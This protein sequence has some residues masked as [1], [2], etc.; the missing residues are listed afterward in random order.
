MKTRK[1]I[2]QELNTLKFVWNMAKGE[3]TK[4]LIVVI[5]SILAGIIPAGI[6]FFAKNYLNSFSAIIANTFS[7]DNLI[8]FLSLILVGIFLKIASGIIMGYAM[9]N[10]KKNIDTACVKKFA[11]LPHTYIADCLD[12]RVIMSVSMESGMIAALIPMVYNSFIKAP[13][14]VLGFV[15]LLL[16][17][18]PLLTLIC[19]LL[20]FTIVVGVTLFRK[21]IKELNKTTY[22]KIGDLHQYFA[23]WLNGYKVFVVSNAV[24][25]IEKQLL[26][27]VNDL[28]KLMKKMTKIGAFQS[29]LIELATIIIVILFITAATKS[30]FTNKTLNIGEFILFPTAILFIR[31]EILKIIDGYMQLARTESAAKR[32]LGI[33]NYPVAKTL[34]K[35]ILIEKINSLTLKNVSF[36][37]KNS[38]HI[39]DNANATFT[40]GKI[41]TIIGRSGAGKTTF[42][43]L[44]LRLRNAESGLIFYNNKEIQSIA[45][46][47]LMDKI[48]LVEQEPFIFEGTLAENIYFDKTPN[49]KY[50]LELLQNFE[51]A[52][53]AKNE[54][55]FY[56]TR[57]GQ[58]GRLLSTGEK[59]RIALI[60]ALVRNV[61][62]IFF[63]EATSNLDTCNTKKIIDCIKDIA[64][65]R[66]VIC[67]SH[68]IMLIEQSKIIYEISRGKIY[69]KQY[70]KQ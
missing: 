19:I 39:L 31:G 57:I 22:D 65:D 51:L 50:V 49:I 13:V 45:E 43:N 63:D 14:T 61:D 68:D 32:I 46:Q 42:I 7:N 29:L 6:A 44:C 5:I 17:V 47:S 11:M 64:K 37:Y 10:V 38:E 55:E 30:T 56:N 53:L 25:Y 60:R 40:R 2:Q 20:I 36:A 54:S 16:F 27:I 24:N 9:P 4:I 66:L 69:E 62:V 41:H 52:H 3:H 70:G 58:R 59:Q 21:T 12:N 23:E 26:N 8:L 33:I 35:E 15:I 34:D 48:G 18:S 1:E 67:V 28:N